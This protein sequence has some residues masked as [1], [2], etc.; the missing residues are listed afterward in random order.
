MH[1]LAVACLNIQTQHEKT[2]DV[3]TALSLWEPVWSQVQVAGTWSSM[4]PDDLAVVAATGW[5][6]FMR[7]KQYERALTTVD[8]LFSDPAFPRVDQPSHAYIACMR[9]LALLYTEEFTKGIE[10]YRF[11][12]EEA[13][14]QGYKISPR[15]VRNQ[16][17]AYVGEQITTDTSPTE[18]IALVDIVVGH[19]PDTNP[20]VTSSEGMTFGDL[21][22]RLNCN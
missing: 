21:S 1:E 12:L 7:A 9:A 22:S 18:L 2:G 8:M 13:S 16:L 3:D 20:A 10:G 17:C 6:L 4:P 19:L 5:T 11:V 15:I 14:R